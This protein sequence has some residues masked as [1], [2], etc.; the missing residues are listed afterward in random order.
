MHINESIP[1]QIDRKELECIS[2]LAKALPENSTVVELGS[3]FGKSSWHWAKNASNSVNIYCVDPW[4]RENWIKKL[5]RRFNTTF[6]LETFW[7]NVAESNNITA[8]Q[9]YSPQ[10]FTDWN[11]PLDIYF[12]DSVHTNPIFRENLYFWLER[13]KPGSIMCGHAYCASCPDLI[14]EVDRLAEK[15]S[16]Q[17]EII[18]K[19]WIIRLPVDYKSPI[20]LESIK[21]SIQPD[22]KIETHPSHLNSIPGMMK[23]SELSLLYSLARN[24]FSDK[25]EIV[26]LGPFLGS[27]TACFGEGIVANERNI[28]KSYKRIYSYDLFRY[29][30]YVG[31]DGLLEPQDLTTGSFF[32]AYLNNVMNHTDLNL[33]NITPGDLCQFK[34]DSKPIEILFIDASKSINLNDH[35]VKHFFP[36]LFPGSIIVQ[37]DYYFHGC[38]WVYPSMELFKPWVSYVGEAVGGTAYFVVNKKIPRVF[39]KNPLSKMINS[40]KNIYYFRQLIDKPEEYSYKDKILLLKFCYYLSE[41]DNNR[42]PIIELKNILPYPGKSAQSNTWE[43]VYQWNYKKVFGREASLK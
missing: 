26:D 23:P 41:S 35:I 8:L 20:Y 3:L 29:E 28:K 21:E 2:Q 25:G 32:T 22:F 42:E 31:F 7:E 13:M 17:L 11:I 37:Q 1:G 40:N 16:V 36:A 34:W 18:G 5:E 33:I 15:L 43:Q 6:S 38:P 10:D 27:S 19:I 12:D 4:Q 24:Y 39:T 30:K 9:A 14:K